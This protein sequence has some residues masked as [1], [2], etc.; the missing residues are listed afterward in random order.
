[1]DC[2]CKQTINKCIVLATFPPSI[3][4]CF[5]NDRLQLCL[6]PISEN[7][8]S[9]T[10]C[11]TYFEDEG[12]HS[13]SEKSYLFLWNE[14]LCLVKESCLGNVLL[15]NSHLRGMI[16]GRWTHL[17]CLRRSLERV[18]AISQDWHLK[19]LIFSWTVLIW[20]FIS[21]LVV[22]VLLQVLH[23][24]FFSLWTEFTWV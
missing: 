19:S 2:Y 6:T 24:C 9:I 13:W 17:K 18:N 21:A 12:P 8:P 20:I 5:K 14:L 1:M 22:K 7:A 11:C 16:F 23:L 4:A 3:L 10:N 15:H